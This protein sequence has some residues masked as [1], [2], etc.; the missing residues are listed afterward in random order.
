MAHS[1]GRHQDAYTPEGLVEGINS[2]NGSLQDLVHEASG[3]L[4]VHTSTFSRI[5]AQVERE[6][7]RADARA[8]DN[9]RMRADLEQ[10]KIRCLALEE[11]AHGSS[12][13]AGHVDDAAP[14]RPRL[15]STTCVLE[16]LAHELVAPLQTVVESVDSLASSSLNSGQKKTLARS[17]TS[18]RILRTMLDTAL[19]LPAILTGEL[20]LAVELVDL[21]QVVDDVIGML[22]PIAAEKGLT[23]SGQFDPA[24]PQRVAGDGRRLRQV[25]Q[26]VLMQAI[27]FSELE[28]IVVRITVEDTSTTDQLVQFGV[29]NAGKGISLERLQAILG[30]ADL[31]PGAASAPNREVHIGLLAVKRIAGLMGGTFNARGLGPS[32]F[33]LE[34]S[35]V[36]G[37]P[38]TIGA[39]R[40]EVKGRILQQMLQSNLGP[41]IDL[42]AGG[43]RI[44]TRRVPKRA[45]D[46]WLF[47]NDGSLQL[48][49]KAVWSKPAGNQTH[50]VGLRFVKLNDDTARAVRKIANQ[51]GLLK[52]A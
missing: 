44:L 37:E 20:D 12:E 49:A 28:E 24:V 26:L 39:E 11:G 4:H 38:S 31:A 25:L 18:L 13:P 41:V 22:A 29:Q 14:E 2:A 47:E 1:Q 51:H 21:G 45:V 42:S 23:L 43:A 36:L 50:E 16:A 10:L 7:S 19:D 5:V 40:R 33:A 8:D 48:K 30:R 6:T 52:V 27:R 15:D 9:D 34:F 17:S 32:G 35:A 3:S 46:L